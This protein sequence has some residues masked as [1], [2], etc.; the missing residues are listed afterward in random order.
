MKCSLDSSSSLEEIS[1]LSHSIVFLYFL[2]LFI[3]EDLLISPC[4]SLKICI[5]FVYLSLFPSLFTSLF[6]S[7]ICKARGKGKDIQT[8]CR[9]SENSKER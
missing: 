4:Y 6:S 7:V 9:F 5:Q 3:E 8:E 1:R 2:A